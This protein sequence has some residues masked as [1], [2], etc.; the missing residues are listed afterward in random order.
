MGNKTEQREDAMNSRF[1]LLFR[2]GRGYFGPLLCLLLIVVAS[3]LIVPLMI[4]AG[5]RLAAPEGILEAPP[6]HAQGMN[7]VYLPLVVK[8]YY[9]GWAQVKSD[10]FGD[11]NNSVGS[12]AV[13]GDYLYAG[14][15]N[16]FWGGEVWRSSDGTTWTQVNTG[17]FAGDP[18]NQ[19]VS[20]LAVFGN[21]LYAG[22]FN[23]HITAAAQLWRT[24]DGT[25]WT[26]VNADGFG[27]LDNVAVDSIA[28]FGDYLYAGTF[29]YSTGGE[30]WRSSD[31]TTWTQ[32]NTDGFGEPNNSAVYSLAVFGNYLYAGTYNDSTGG[33]IWRIPQ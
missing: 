31:G 11:P 30:V 12:L 14:T 8:N 20:S 3:F 9:R 25:T 7:Y 2:A 1:G 6:A 13:F 17:G 16:S 15:Y 32:V 24:P 33:E 22:T 21:Y 29:N 26:Q 27:D 19:A 4:R 10:G 5:G 18:N 28:V 23:G